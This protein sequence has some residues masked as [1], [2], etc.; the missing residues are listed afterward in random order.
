MSVAALYIPYLKKPDV[1]MV[2]FLIC[3]RASPGLVSYVS[4]N[5]DVVRTK[6][7]EMGPVYIACFGRGCQ[8]LQNFTEQQ[9]LF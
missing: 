2:V 6:D 3:R 8:N 1:K 5:F 7:A 4:L 9:T